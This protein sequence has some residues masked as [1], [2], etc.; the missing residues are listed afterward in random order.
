MPAYTY[1]FVNRSVVYVESVIHP[2][3]HVPPSHPPPIPR[4][5]LLPSPVASQPEGPPS[6][7][8]SSKQRE[9]QFPAT[10]FRRPTGYVYMAPK[11]LDEM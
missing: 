11:H 10:V 3:F 9:A 5:C 2:H 1:G 8:P 7:P 4:L 6:W